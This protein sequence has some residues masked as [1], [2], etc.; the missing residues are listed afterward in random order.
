MQTARRTMLR[1]GLGSG[2]V[3]AGAA[4]AEAAGAEVFPGHPDWRLVFVNHVTTNPFFVPTRY[5][6]QDACDLLG[7]DYQW[8]GS[9]NSDV[10]E[11]VNAMNAAIA[12][13]AAAIAVPLIDPKAFNGPTDRA[14]AAGIPVFAYN[15]D[16]TTG[17]GNKR[18]A[19]IGQDL[20][21]AGALMGERIVRMV[22]G[23]TIAL[24]IATPGALNLQP[25]IDGARDAIGRAA[26]RSGKNYDVQVIATGAT[27]NEEISKVEAFYLGHQDVK[28]HVRGGWR[29]HA[30]RRRGDEQAWPGRQRRHRWRIRSAA[31][32]AFADPGGCAAF[33][34][35]PAALSAR[36]LHRDADVHI[37]GLWRSGRA[38]GLQYRA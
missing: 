11:M 29:Q 1:A 19:Y 8:T 16:A 9:A 26:S 18:L 36:L 32:H 17:S 38:G 3:V 34:H 14:L 6:M 5:G 30:G 28:G 21:R 13:K 24:F 22:D 25:R 35:R 4:V 2:L 27:V 15:A 7:C 20:Y 31:A 33:Y 23:G 37:S 10:A 12:A